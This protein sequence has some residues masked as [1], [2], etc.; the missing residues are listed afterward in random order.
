[1]YRTLVNIV[2]AICL[3]LGPL[4]DLIWSLVTPTG[5]TAP[6]KDNVAALI[7]HPAAAHA[8]V[9]LDLAIILLIP[10]ALFAGRV[11]Q[12]SVRPLAG[13]G[14]GLLFLG[15]LLFTYSLGNDVVVL[16]AAQTNGAATAQAYADSGV[17][18]LTTVLAIAFQFVGVVLLGI[19]ALRS[20]LIP[21]WAAV[22]LIAWNPVQAIGTASGISMVETLGNAML[23]AAY[24]AIAVRLFRPSSRRVSEQSPLVT[25]STAR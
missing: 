5:E 11:L 8:A 19:S 7:A 14:T 13:F 6:A 2:G 16:A 3:I 4:G 10:A 18:S 17:V 20:R 12:S 23:L 15:S 9:W 21:V 24:A 22:L 1:M 25:A